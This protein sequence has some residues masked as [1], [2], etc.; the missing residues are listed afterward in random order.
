MWYQTFP[1]DLSGKSTKPCRF[2]YVDNYIS[3]LRPC[4]KDTDVARNRK[5]LPSCYN[6]SPMLV[7]ATYVYTRYITSHSFHSYPKWG[8][9]SISPDMYR[10]DY[11]APPSP[12]AGCTEN[13]RPNNVNL[14]CTPQYYLKKKK[15]IFLHQLR[16]FFGRFVSTSSLILDFDF[17][18]FEGNL[19]ALKPGW[20]QNV[21]EKFTCII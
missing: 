14:F 8:L 5:Y 2:R 20:A 10:A 16:T 4:R 3:Y 17:S 13:D 19:R 9:I 6:R 15:K 1:S 21:A 7:R 18:V 12:Q 11:L